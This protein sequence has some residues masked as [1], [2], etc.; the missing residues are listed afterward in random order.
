MLKSILKTLQGDSSAALKQHGEQGRELQIATC[1]LLLEIAHADDEFLPE[2]EQKIEMLMRKHFSLP[3]DVFR[4]IKD[5]SEKKRTESIDLWHLTKTIK[6]HYSWEQ[7]EKIIEMIWGIIYTDGT[8]N[9]HEDYL[10][11]KLAALLDLD[12]RALIDAKVKVLRQIRQ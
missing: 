3:E 4:E 5:L 7:K 1:A 10:A 8:L 12:H 2:E 6:E 11:H 9:E